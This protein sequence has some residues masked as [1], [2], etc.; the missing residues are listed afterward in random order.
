MSVSV[1]T[2]PRAFAAQILEGGYSC[3]SILERCPAEWHGL[4]MEHVRVTQDR[5]DMNVARQQKFRPPAKP[6]IPQTATYQEQHQVRG[7]PVV[8]AAHLA[9]VR[10][11]INSNRAISQ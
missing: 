6:S 1:A 2:T 9:A 7:N 10:A 11:S 4:V 3:E 8:A 5:R